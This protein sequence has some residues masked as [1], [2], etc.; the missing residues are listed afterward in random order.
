M[1]LII[2]AKGKE[3]F[4]ID[5]TEDISLLFCDEEFNYSSYG[6]ASG[7]IMPVLKGHMKSIF[8]REK[9]ERQ[10]YK[11]AGREMSEPFR[12]MFNYF[13]LLAKR[14]KRFKSILEDWEKSE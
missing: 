12:K 8:G 13:Q 1:K 9:R 14:D 2:Q 7:L 3:E 10:Y 5:E 11:D 4:V 6:A